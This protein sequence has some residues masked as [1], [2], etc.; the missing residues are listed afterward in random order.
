[1]QTPCTSPC[2]VIFSDQTRNGAST[3]QRTVARRGPTLSSSTKTRGLPTSQLMLPIRR[4][5]TPRRI[6]VEEPRGASMVA[7][8]VLAFGRQSTQARPGRSSK[9]ADFL[10]DYSEESVSMSRAQI[11]TSFTR[12]WKL[13][14]VLEQAVRNKHLAGRL[15]QVRVRR[16]LDRHLQP[17]ASR[18][19]R[20][21]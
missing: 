9:V 21:H 6:N 14:R 4:H 18:Q 11:R 5:S 17:P 12:R 15:P 1:M 20:Q 7:V 19:A 8:R 16:L 13:A 3:R 2:S 10:K